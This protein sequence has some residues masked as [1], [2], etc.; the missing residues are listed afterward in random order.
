[1]EVGALAAELDT[2]P[3]MVEAMLEHLERRGA[4]QTCTQPGA[5]CSACSQGTT[6]GLK[7][8]DQIRLWQGTVDGTD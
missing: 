3:A 1:M 2:S 5:A 8:G 6:C 4:V 7:F